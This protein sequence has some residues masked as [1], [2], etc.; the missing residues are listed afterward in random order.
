MLTRWPLLTIFATGLLLFIV[1]FFSGYHWAT[2]DHDEKPPSESSTVEQPTSPGTEPS[3]EDSLVEQQ[4]VPAEML[5]FEDWEGFLN[6]QGP[7]TSMLGIRR[8]YSQVNLRKGPG[9]NFPIVDRLTGGQ[10][11]TEL[12][13]FEGW[14]RV[15]DKTGRLGW[16]HSS[17]VRN[18]RTPQPV[19]EKFLDRLPPL[20]ES[21]QQKIS[22]PPRTKTRAEI[23]T[24]R[25]NLRQGPGTQFE[26]V[27]RA[28]KYQI[29][30]L[31]S[32]HNNWTYLELSDGRAVWIHASLI[33]IIKPD[34]T[35]ADPVKLTEEIA[36]WPSP[37]RQFRSLTT[38]EP[39]TEIFPLE[40]TNDWQLISTNDNLGWL[41]PSDSDDTIMR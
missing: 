40:T 30:R 23:I 21:T 33:K 36:I 20:A 15:R 2:S 19:A 1:A 26:I 38:L 27:G 22:P 34:K 32:Q 16:L 10:L 29:F 4:P 39:G 9:T 13:F 6:Y 24:D 11:L 25:S 12:D 5:G 3:R 31:L 14:Y 8:E 41:P 18:I 35:T 28:Y 37:R 17:L 7:R